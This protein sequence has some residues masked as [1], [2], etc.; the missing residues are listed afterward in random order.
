VNAQRRAWLDLVRLPNAITA[1]ADVLAGFLFAGGVARQS[2]EVAFACIA[3]VLLYMGGVA[4]NDYCDV[5]I[6]A[7]E[8]PERPIPSG[9]VAKR[10]ALRIIVAFLAIG[11]ALAALARPSAGIAAILL[12]V[13][14]VLYNAVLKLTPL[15]PVLMGT[16]RGLNFLVGVLV[17]G[18]A[19]GS[20]WW[21]AGLIWLYITSVTY[22]ARKE[23]QAGHRPRLVLGFAGVMA[24]VLGLILMNFYYDPTMRVSFF[25]VVI[26]AVIVARPGWRAVRSTEPR[27]VQRAIK[28]WILSLIL[29]DACIAATARGWIAGLA[30]AALLPL[31]LLASRAY[32]V[33]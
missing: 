14:I 3:S 33:T 21:P 29:F 13:A 12:V 27:D 11:I 17:V 20:A 19:I 9:R 23:T 32:R 1:P 7:R 24:A 18:G 8:R 10:A 26:F 28:V 22:F 31:A 15:A 16:C 4:L 5:D 6:D 25:L 2:L 30:V